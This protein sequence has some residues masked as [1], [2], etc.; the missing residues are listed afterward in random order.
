MT[1]A[2]TAMKVTTRLTE[3]LEIFARINSSQIGICRW[4]LESYVTLTGGVSE[5]AAIFSKKPFDLL[6]DLASRFARVARL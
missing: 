3:P 2:V 5:E 1:R 4:R 6:L